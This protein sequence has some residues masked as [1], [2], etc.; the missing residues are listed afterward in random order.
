MTNKQKYTI[1]QV[2]GIID[3]HLDSNTNFMFICNFSL[4]H[5]IYD[6]IHNDYGIDAE[7][8]E[9]SSDVDEYYISL[10]FYKNEEI[11]FFCEFAK[12]DDGTY[13]YDEVDNIDYYV[14]SDMSFGDVREFLAGKGKV[15]FC[16]F[17]DESNVDDVELE[18]E[19]Y[20]CK[21]CSCDNDDCD[22]YN[23]TCGKPDCDEVENGNVDEYLEDE[24]CIPCQCV[25]CKMSRGELTDDEEYEIGLVEHYAQYIENSECECGSELRNILYS[26]LQECMSMGYENKQEEINES[27]VEESKVI[28]IYIDNI[29]FP[30]VKDNINDFISGIKD[31]AIKYSKQ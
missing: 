2:E 5:Y 8:M 22:E 11:G 27:D 29:Q 14:M 7:C 15:I 26:M 12:M 24:N 20:L 19:S 16:E 23:C 1:S 25:E 13:K 18:E 9:L 4:A 3:S 31:Y 6:Y 28:N 30:N 21:C 10:Q 17:V